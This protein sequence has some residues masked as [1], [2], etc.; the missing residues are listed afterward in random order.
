MLHIHFDIRLLV[1]NT[2]VRES[3]V[4]AR[5]QL[6]QAVLWCLFL[7]ISIFATLHI[8]PLQV[9]MDAAM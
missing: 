5:D 2:G 9:Q 6:V 4:A 3:Y 8:W 1:Q 7:H